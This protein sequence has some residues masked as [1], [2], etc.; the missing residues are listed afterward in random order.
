M[1]CVPKDILDFSANEII[2]LTVFNSRVGITI[3]QRSGYISTRAHKIHK[4]TICLLLPDLTVYMD[5]SGQVAT[6]QCNI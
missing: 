6:L 3:S 1:I 2:M 5:G 4:I